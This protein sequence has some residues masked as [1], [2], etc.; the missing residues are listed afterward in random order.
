MQNPWESVMRVKVRSR[1]PFVWNT[2]HMFQVPL[3][4]GPLTGTMSRARQ[5]FWWAIVCSG[6]VPPHP[7]SPP[8]PL[9]WQSSQPH[10]AELPRRT[11]KA[12]NRFSGGHRSPV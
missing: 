2:P 12:H 8:D 6:G 3:D 5:S 7:P 9:T 10:A 4:A 11:R 1:R